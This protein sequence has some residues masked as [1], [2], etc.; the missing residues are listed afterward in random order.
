MSGEEDEE[1][2]GEDQLGSLEEA[3]PT[4][5]GFVSSSLNSIA[6]HQGGLTAPATIT[7]GQT[8][9]NSNGLQTLSMPMSLTQRG[10]INA[11][12]L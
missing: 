12:A 9:S 4:D 7:P 1:F 6:N 10:S 3:S 5:G 11:G 8:Y 2:S